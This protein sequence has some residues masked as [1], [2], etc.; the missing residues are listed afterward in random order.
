LFLNLQSLQAG[1][2][3][4]GL[5]LNCVDEVP[6]EVPANNKLQLTKNKRK[7]QKHR[8][9]GNSNKIRITLTDEQ[10][11]DLQKDYRPT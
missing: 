6:A 11:I 9:H 10:Q 4:E 5:L 7:V 1:Q 8:Y 3:G 2:V